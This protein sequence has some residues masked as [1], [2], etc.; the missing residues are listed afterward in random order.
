GDVANLAGEIRSHR[1]H[2]VGEI[3][4][5]AGDTGHLCLPAELALGAHLAGHPAYFAGETVELIDH[6]IDR[7]LQLQNLTPHVDGDLA[8]QIAARDR[9]G[10]RGNIPDLRSQIGSHGVD[11]I[12]EIFPRTSDT[13]HYGLPAETPLRTHLTG[14]ACDFRCEAVELID[15]R[16]DRVLQLQNLAAYVDGNLFGQIPVCHCCRHIRDIANLAGEVGRHEV[17][18]IGQIL[19][20]TPDAQHHS[21]ATEPALGTDFARH[22]ADLRGECVELIDHRID[23][24]LQLQNLAPHFDSNLLG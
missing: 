6:R 18:I 16:I 7:I 1:V 8:R 20:C 15:H 14:H 5:R 10:H 19:P 17:H 9:R 13:R 11:R 3:L 12:G 22:T 23:R 4:P 24:V 21:L 2:I